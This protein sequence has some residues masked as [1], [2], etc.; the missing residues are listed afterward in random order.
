M[1]QHQRSGAGKATNNGGLVLICIRKVKSPF[2]D[3]GLEGF[4]KPADPTLT[5]GESTMLLGGTSGGGIRQFQAA[6]WVGYGRSCSSSCRAQPYPTTAAAAITVTTAT[7]FEY[8]GSG[9]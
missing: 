8:C 5:Y 7:Q 6:G 4:E 9:P 1:S 2:R 3:S